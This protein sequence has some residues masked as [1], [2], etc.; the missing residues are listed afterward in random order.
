MKARTLKGSS[1]V[2]AYTPGFAAD[3]AGWTEA[4]LDALVEQVKV[5]RDTR[6]LTGIEQALREVESPRVTSV[7]DVNRV[8]TPMYVGRVTECM[9]VLSLAPHHRL[10]AVDVVSEGTATYTAFNPAD[11][12][13]TVLVRGCSSFIL[14]HNHPSGDCAPSTEDI[15]ATGTLARACSPLGVSFLDHVIWSDFRVHSMR[16]HGEIPFTV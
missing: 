10:V 9:L 5:C 2:S 12:L 4:R 6:M 14:S 13:R 16:E 8:A 1:A 7:S 15:R 3:V 11:I